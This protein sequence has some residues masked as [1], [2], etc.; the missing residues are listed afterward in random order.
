MGSSEPPCKGDGSSFRL[1]LSGNDMALLRKILKAKGATMSGLLVAVMMHSL[2]KEYTGE[3]PRDVAVSMLVDL[4]PHLGRASHDEQI[5]QAHGTVTLL[6]S[7]NNNN[8]D[9]RT[10]DC[11]DDDDDD[12]ASLLHKIILQKSLEMTRQLRTRIERG[13]AHRAALALTAGQFGDAGPSATIEMSN[14]GVCKIPEGTKMYTAQRFDG[15]DGVSC[16]V[17]S[18]SDTGRM[19]WNVSVGEGLDAKLVERVLVRAMELCHRICCKI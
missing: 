7:I 17:H 8:N 6:D 3:A 11:G 4:R 18:E 1:E 13:E 15:Y 16:M 14:L 9:L 12:E 2:S 5:P 19:Q 10:R